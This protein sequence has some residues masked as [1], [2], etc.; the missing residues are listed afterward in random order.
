MASACWKLLVL[1]GDIK[2][3]RISSRLA[4]FLSAVRP[5]H[6]ERSEGPMHFF[7]SCRFSLRLFSALSAVKSFR[8]SS[9]ILCKNTLTE[10]R[11]LI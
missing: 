8:Q 1:R 11:A 3:P 2:T 4:I 7:G 9:A 10:Y 6:P 5:R